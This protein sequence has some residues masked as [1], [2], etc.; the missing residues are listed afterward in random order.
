MRGGPVAT[1]SVVQTTS[2][3]YAANQTLV[4]TFQEAVHT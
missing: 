2:A 4:V 3:H 1:E